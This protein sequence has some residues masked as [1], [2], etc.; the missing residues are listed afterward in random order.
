MTP[1]HSTARKRIAVIGSGPSCLLLLKNLLKCDEPSFSLDVF[2]SGSET[3]KG[4]PYSREGA[5]EEHVTNVSGNEIPELV[6][7]TQDW[8]KTLPE[9]ILNKYA[10]NLSDFND[11]HVFPRLL[12][13]QYLQAQFE[14]YMEMATRKNI[15]IRLHLN[16]TVTNIKDRKEQQL[17]DVWAGDKIFADFNYVVVCSGHQWPAGQEKKH[18]G[19][20]DSPY[21]PAKLARTF[22]H[23]VAIKGSSLTAIDAI[24]T[25]ALH[26]GV[27]HEQEAGKYIFRGNESAPDFKLVLYSIKGLLPAVRFHLEDSHLTGAALLSEKDIQSHRRSNDGFVSLDF[28]FEKDFKEV[29]R[30][31]DPVFYEHFKEMK[32][33]AFVDEMMKLREQADPF[34][35]MRAELAEARLSI[36]RRKSVYWKEMLGSLS[37]ALNYPAKYFSAEDK[38]RLQQKLM[39]LISVIIAYVPQD[40]CEELLALHDAGRLSIIAVEK[41]SYVTVDP[42]DGILYHHT[43]E[44]GHDQT[45]SYSSFIDCIGQPHLWLKDFP[46]KSLIEDG[47]ISQATLQYQCAATGAS[48]FVEDPEKIIRK[49]ANYFLQ[50]PGIAITD[51]FNVIGT[52]KK[53]NPRIYMMAVPFIGGYNPDYSGLDF[54]AFASEKIVSTILL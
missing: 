33:E 9:P 44:T 35:L 53:A 32:M 26:N 27:F 15:S 51:N 25:L 34:Q 24:R 46:F 31:K 43:N 48:A 19:W 23:P 1:T 49:D 13:G 22:N 28:I 50:V 30:T 45:D 11:Y 42:Q 18:P 16:C 14:L 47:V 36:R 37:A 6:T 52:D 41:D 7:S 12:F 8:L 54:C 39:P 10:I 4:F 20:F 29:L 2:E 3:G 21:P 17:T 5:S 38:L 40:S